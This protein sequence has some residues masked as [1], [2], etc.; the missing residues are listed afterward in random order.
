MK[1]VS[2]LE[3]IKDVFENDHSN[4]IIDMHFISI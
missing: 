3:F 2:N 1:S 4:N